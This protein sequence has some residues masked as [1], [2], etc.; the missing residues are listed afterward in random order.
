MR[1][2]QS[3][4][5]RDLMDPSYHKRPEQIVPEDTQTAEPDALTVTLDEEDRIELHHML[6][7]RGDSDTKT[8]LLHALATLDAN[9]AA[10]LRRLKS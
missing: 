7:G 10:E 5:L 9:R 6:R 4:H 8:K 3:S 2:R 1:K